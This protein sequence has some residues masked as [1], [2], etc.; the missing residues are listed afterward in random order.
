MTGHEQ[1]VLPIMANLNEHVN[2][3][4]AIREAMEKDALER[5]AKQHAMKRN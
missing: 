2:V 5:A 1:T 3:A 4:L